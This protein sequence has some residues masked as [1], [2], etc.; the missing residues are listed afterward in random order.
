MLLAIAIGVGGAVLGL[1][2]SFWLDAASGA[3][4]VLIETAAFLLALALGPRTGLLSMRR[5]GTLAA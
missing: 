3:T 2:A 1:Y 5:R 4:I